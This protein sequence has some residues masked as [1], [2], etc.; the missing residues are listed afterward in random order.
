M[1][2]VGRVLTCLHIAIDKHVGVEEEVVYLVG[3]RFSEHTVHDMETDSRPL[4]LK[5]AGTGT[6]PRAH[7]IAMAS[8]RFA[9]WELYLRL[10]LGR[11]VDR[12]SPP[13]EPLG[14]DH[15]LEEL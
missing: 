7:N 9:R 2:G 14:G 4:L 15:I 5:Q 12:E 6:H 1:I 3:P 13:L 11:R 10:A 8:D